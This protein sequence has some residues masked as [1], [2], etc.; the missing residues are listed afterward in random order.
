MTSH[1]PEVTGEALPLTRS[2]W[3][4]QHTCTAAARD[5]F[6]RLRTLHTS[7]IH[8]WRG[9]YACIP[10]RRS[11]LC[12]NW[13]DPQRRTEAKGRTGINKRD[14]VQPSECQSL[15]TTKH[16]FGGDLWNSR[17]RSSPS[18]SFALIST[19]RKRRSFL[20]CSNESW[21]VGRE[22]YVRRDRMRATRHPTWASLQLLPS[23]S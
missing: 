9:G 23:K 2:P 20:S 6:F 15:P 16:L 4:I 5:S 7:H 12:K 3:W 18:C 19:P 8:L 17:G 13:V 22:T 10:E 14:D 11:S 1:F 21:L